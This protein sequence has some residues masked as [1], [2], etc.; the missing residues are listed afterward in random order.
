[1][2]AVTRGMAKKQFSL[3]PIVFGVLLLLGSSVEAGGSLIGT[4]QLMMTL[5]M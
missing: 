2:Q 1:M 5:I 4:E 3:L